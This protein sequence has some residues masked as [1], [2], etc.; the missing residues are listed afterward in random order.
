MRNLV[1]LLVKVGGI[2][3]LGLSKATTLFSEVATLGLI[4]AVMLELVII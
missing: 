4:K 2:A 3:T 1:I